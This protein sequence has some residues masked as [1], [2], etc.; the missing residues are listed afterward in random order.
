MLAHEKA[1]RKF[2]RAVRQRL[3]AAEFLA[4]NG[5]NLDA[6]YL[7]GYAVECALKVLILTRTPAARFEKI[8]EEISTGKKA[9]DFEFLKYVYQKRPLNGIIS[10]AVAEHLQDVRNWKT[11]LRYESLAVDSDAASAFIASARQIVEW[12]ERSV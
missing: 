7:A 12:M 4:E 10:A 2:R 9:H 3:A 8:Y 5:Y 11:D 1:V 6:V